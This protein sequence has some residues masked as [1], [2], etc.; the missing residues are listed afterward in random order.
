MP[1]VE[2]SFKNEVMQ[3]FRDALS[4]FG[5]RGARKILNMALNKK[6]RVSLTAV[7]RDLSKV[8]GMTYDTVNQAVEEKKSSPMT[9]EYKI[10]GHGD[11]TNLRQFKPYS[12]ARSFSAAPWNERRQFPNTFQPGP[13]RGYDSSATVYHRIG[14]TR[15]IAPS[16]G[17][18]IAREMMKPAVVSGWTFVIND[19]LPEVAR[20]IKLRLERAG[21]FM[22]ED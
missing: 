1:T 2:I 9:L 21:P 20:L 3:N 19:V 8:T 22:Y 6:G 10:I 18:N 4:E 16:Y 7:K 5:D 12:G 13:P 15:E 11:W 14:Q 17:P